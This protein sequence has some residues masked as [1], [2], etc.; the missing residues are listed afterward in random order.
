VPDPAAFASL[1]DASRRRLLVAQTARFAAAFARW[2][3]SQACDGL[4]YPRLRVLETLASNGPRMMRELAEQL[5]I[6]ARNTTAVVDA[7][8]GAGLVARR[9]HPT[10]RRATLVELTPGG[11]GATAALGPT[12]DSLGR[13]FDGFAAADE[14]LFFASVGRLLDAM[15]A[16]CADR[17]TSDIAVI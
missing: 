4:S 13:L 7:L 6:S 17:G 3:D 5:G 15:Q 11:A 16:G 8:E 9:P 12:F 10:D 2:M 1:D 14:E